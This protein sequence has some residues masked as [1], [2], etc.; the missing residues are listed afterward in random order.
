LAKSIKSIEDLPP[1][2]KITHIMADGRELDSLDG[3]VIP[4]TPDTL[5]IYELLA[6]YAQN[7]PKDKKVCTLRE[8]N[9][10]IFKGQSQ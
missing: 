10:S 7:V 8:L 9:L 4:Y 2:F 6:K 3:V 1:G 5:L